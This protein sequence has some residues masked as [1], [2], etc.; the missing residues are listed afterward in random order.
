MP[1]VERL[2][3]RANHRAVAHHHAA[4]QRLHAEDFAEK[5]FRQTNSLV[6]DEVVR[7]T[8]HLIVRH[9]VEVTKRIRIAERPVLGEALA[10]VTALHVVEA[11][12]ITAVV[13][14]KHPALRV[15]LHPKRVAA[16]LGEHLVAA[17]P[18][19]VAPDVLA[20]R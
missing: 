10:Q 16:A 12:C 6:H 7:E 13:P 11:P 5:L 20:H 8:R 3:R 18:G 4:L 9:R 19:M 14:G 17:R 1:R 2:E 15:E